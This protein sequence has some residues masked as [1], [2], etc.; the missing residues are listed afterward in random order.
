MREAEVRVTRGCACH[1]RNDAVWCG[2]WPLHRGDFGARH[3]AGFQSR[4]RFCFLSLFHVTPSG[5]AAPLS[6]AP[7]TLRPLVRI[8]LCT[9]YARRGGSLK[10]SRRAT[11]RVA[12]LQ[13]LE[14]DRQKRPS[15]QFA[16]RRCVNAGLCT[17][18]LR[19][20]R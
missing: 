1:G 14:R 10:V 3:A 12:S 6:A 2:L 16:G 7:G 5:R 18:A 11:S 9:L 20:P 19:V 4:S 8:P 15:S 13:S 17:A